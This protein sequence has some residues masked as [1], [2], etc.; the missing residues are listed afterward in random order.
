MIMDIFEKKAEFHRRQAQLPIEQKIKILIALQKITLTIR[1][2]QGEDDLRMVW[3]L[4]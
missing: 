3:E 2:K 4:E 1:P